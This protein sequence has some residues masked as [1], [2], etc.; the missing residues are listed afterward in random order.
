MQRDRVREKGLERD[1][2]YLKGERIVMHDN[3]DAARLVKAS[4][5]E[6]Q[7]ATWSKDYCGCVGKGGIACQ[8]SGW[9]VTLELCTGAIDDSAYIDKVEI[10]RLQEEFAKND[11]TSERPFTN[12]FD[13]GYRC[14]L[15]ALE[16]G[17]HCCVC[18]PL[19]LRVI[20]NLTQIMLCIR[21]ALP[22]F[23]LGTIWE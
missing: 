17:L 19:L 1:F 22:L 2:H 21:L 15:A 3:M 20:G 12:I 18:N 16:Q 8:L 10:L 13:K 7:R 6:M 5:P 4:D 9:T 23:D 14:I 11:P